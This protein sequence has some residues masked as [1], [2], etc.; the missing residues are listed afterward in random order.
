MKKSILKVGTTCAAL[1]GILFLFEIAPAQ[2]PKIDLAIYD[3]S[4]EKIPG[5]DSVLVNFRIE[6]AVADSIDSSNVH[7]MVKFNGSPVT[8]GYIGVPTILGDCYVVA[9][10]PDGGCAKLHYNC[11]G[12]PAKGSHCYCDGWL[13]PQDPTI[14]MEPSPGTTVTI[15]IDDDSTLHE[16]DE[17]NNECSTV[18][19]VRTTP[20]STEWGR[21]MLGVVLL[22]FMAWVLLKRKK[23]IGVRS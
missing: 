18:Y 3:C 4:I 19:T 7:Y 6:H 20:S 2:E 12:P 9:L 16:W 13:V 22:G 10:C 5:K 1:L 17:T 11:L 21:I 14:C 15:M 8:S 23:V